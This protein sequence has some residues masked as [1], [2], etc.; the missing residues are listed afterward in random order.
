MK[1]RNKVFLIISILLIIIVIYQAG[2]T[3]A[4]YVSAR[5]ENA[6]GDFA[7][8]N[9]IVN[10]TDIMENK[11]IEKQSAMMIID[12]D[13]ENKFFSK[14]IFAPG[15]RGYFEINIDYSG[16]SI[17]FS[18]EIS[19]EN[20]SKNKNIIEYIRIIKD[21]EK[22]KENKEEEDKEAIA[23]LNAD[24]KSKQNSLLDIDNP[25]KKEIDAPNVNDKKITIRV[26]ILWR[27]ASNTSADNSGSNNKLNYNITLKFN[28][29][30]EVTAPP[31]EEPVNP[32][33]IGDRLDK[34][35]FKGPGNNSEK[36]EENDII[37]LNNEEFYVMSID[38]N[39]GDENSAIRMIAKYNLNVGDSKYTSGT[40]GIQNEYCGT[41]DLENPGVEN[42]EAA[43]SYLKRK[44]EVL[45]HERNSDF[46]DINSF[47][48]LEKYD[49]ARAYIRAKIFN[50]NR[51]EFKEIENIFKYEQSLNEEYKE[52]VE[53]LKETYGSNK[54][55][56]SMHFHDPDATAGYWNTRNPTTI[57]INQSNL[58]QHLSNYEKYLKDMNYSSAN[59]NILDLNDI[60]SYCTNSGTNK[61]FVCENKSKIWL[62]N[63]LYWTSAAF[64]NADLIVI[65]NGTI[66]NRSFKTKNVYGIRPVVTIKASDIK[67]YTSSKGNQIDT[68][69]NNTD[70]NTEQTS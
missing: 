41:P 23:A 20:D 28:Q 19:A 50:Q 61:K 24:V 68:S 64:N 2:N 65:N 62:S 18:Y 42:I 1:T 69:N 48:E 29:I 10:N 38:N 9:I 15:R 17:P 37:K 21:N 59:V 54:Y 63:G 58:Q 52:N 27:N 51:Y 6:E 8:W 13:D 5:K 67:E 57:D 36:I 25:L 12:D 11:I 26:Y 31:I 35:I 70:T 46:N 40:E 60:N 44:F 66:K 47:A 49:Y 39:Q 30:G 7:K 55:Y 22:E 16:V 43:K 34:S 56:C 32:L 45:N 14:N 53:Y 33:I 4:K 3:Y